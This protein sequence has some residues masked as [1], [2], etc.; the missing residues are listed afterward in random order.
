MNRLDEFEYC[1]ELL[2]KG[3][4]LPNG[5]IAGQGAVND[6]GQIRIKF[7]GKAYLIHRFVCLYHVRRSPEQIAN[8]MMHKVQQTC[9]F[10]ICIEP[11]HL[12]FDDSKPEKVWVKPVNWWEPATEYRYQ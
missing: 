5:C 1:Q 6:K 10:T 9:R 12:K 2:A 11:S 7:N 4:V 3:K 8:L